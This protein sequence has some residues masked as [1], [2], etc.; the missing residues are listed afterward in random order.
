M[1]KTGVQVNAVKKVVDISVT[2]K[3][4]M[5]DSAAFVAEYNSKTSVIKA[6]EFELNVDCTDMQ[7]LTADMY[8]DLTAVMKL[9][10]STGFK[11][12]KFQIKSNQIL[13]MQLSRIARNAGLTQSSVVDVA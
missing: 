3:M 8:E 9:Y 7:V 1:K 2:G 5:E 4:T 12:V 10:K 11:Q 13:K 6:A